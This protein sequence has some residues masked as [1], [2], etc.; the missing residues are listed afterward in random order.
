MILGNEC[1]IDL[2]NRTLEYWKISRALREQSS[3]E[4]P[5]YL[6]LELLSDTADSL[7]PT[8]RVKHAAAHLLQEVIHGHPLPPPHESDSTTPWY[9]R[10]T[11][12]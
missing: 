12:R 3:E 11:S 6:A 10:F 1:A 5:T 2:N 9:S 7:A 8:R 4:I